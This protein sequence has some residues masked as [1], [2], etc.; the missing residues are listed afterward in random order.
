MRVLAASLS[1][2]ALLAQPCRADDFCD[3][4]MRVAGDAA[5][6]FEHIRGSP[7]YP[8]G[9]RF[10]HVPSPPGTLAYARSADPCSIFP[11]DTAPPPW[12]YVCEFP[13]PHWHKGAPD[14]H[15]IGAHITACLNAAHEDFAVERLRARGA[16]VYHVSTDEADI[17]LG[18][19]FVSDG[20]EPR[21]YLF[22][23]Q[24]TD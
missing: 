16:E 6:G 13:I 5:S 2:I 17:I 8:G 20:G 9:R 19:S 3:T 10:D 23:D 12:R 7:D 18:I 22:I 11:V 1:A 15:A 14:A 4:L 24:R 21:Y